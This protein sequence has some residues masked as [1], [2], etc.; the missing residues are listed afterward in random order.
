MDLF[1]TL[2]WVEILVKTTFLGTSTLIVLC[3][4][5]STKHGVENAYYLP[6][7]DDSTCYL[8]LIIRNSMVGNEMNLLSKG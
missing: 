7:S 5:P 6:V 4:I 3:I 8:D 1:D 2:T